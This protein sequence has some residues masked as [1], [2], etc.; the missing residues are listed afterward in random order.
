MQSLEILEAVR[1]YLERKFPFKVVEKD[2]IVIMGGKE[3]G[4]Y[5]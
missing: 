4:I 1:V 3:E 5:A 2:G